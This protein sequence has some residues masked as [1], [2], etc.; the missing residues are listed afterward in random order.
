MTQVEGPISLRKLLPCFAVAVAS[1]LCWGKG[2]DAAASTAV[3]RI[4]SRAFIIGLALWTFL[5][6][7]AGDA[8]W[9]AEKLLYM[10]LRDS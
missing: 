7:G 3:Q 4:L 1:P 6:L 5:L 10:S 9:L 2:L 8:D